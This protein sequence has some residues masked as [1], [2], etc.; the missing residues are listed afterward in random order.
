MTLQKVTVNLPESIYIRLQQ[1]ARATKQP[2]DQIIIRAVQMGSPPGWEDIPAEYQ[3]DLAALER[4]DD[5]S[6]WRIA[7]F[8]Q[9]ESDAD[10]YRELLDKNKN[11]TL[12]DAE[13]Q[14]LNNLRTESDGVT[15]QKTHAAALLRWRG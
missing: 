3:A 9:T 6:L 10:R 15:L 5:R 1:A 11:G 4:L 7:R 13:R 14:E 2:L 8:R 12:S